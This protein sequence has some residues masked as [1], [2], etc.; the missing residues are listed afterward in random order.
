M[1]WTWQLTTLAALK[2]STCSAAPANA[3]PTAVVKNGTYFG[4][5]NDYYNQDYFLGMPFAQPPVGD[6][7]LAPPV[8]LNTSFS[9]VRNATDFSPG[10]IQF[11][12]AGIDRPLSEDCLSIN[13]IRPS[14]FEN[15]KLPVAVWIYGG[16]YAQGLN[17]DPRYNLTFMVD[18]SVKLGKPIIA[19]SINYRL[20]GFGFLDSTALRAAGLTNLGLR[21]QRLALHWV[22]ENIAA[23]GGNA[24]EV[25]IWGQSAGAGSVGAQLVAYGGRDDGLFRAAITESGGP[26]AFA[27]PTL[28]TSDAT[29]ANILN[30]TGCSGAND[31]I[32]CLRNVPGSVLASAVNA[33]HGS[34]FPH[35][36]NDFLQDYSSVQLSQGK[37]VK[38]P[39][40]TGA[41]ADEGTSFASLGYT[42]TST[43]LNQISAS[44]VSTNSTIRAAGVS[45]IAMLYP[46]IPAIGIPH[47][48]H[49]RPNA[50]YGAQYKRA[51]AFAGDLNIH[52]GRRAAAQAWAEQN[53]PAYS[54]YFNTYPIGGLDPIVG[55]THFAE[56]ALVMNDKAGVGYV[57]P[58][59]PRGSPFAINSSALYTQ[60]DL[61][62]KSL[63]PTFPYY[64]RCTTNL[65]LSRDCFIGC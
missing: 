57:A 34:F 39:L 50:T 40:L 64:S 55:T 51:A 44:I 42:N 45:D 26:L 49:G 15:R 29:Y 48:F 43:I 56:V 54:Y 36:D 31:S 8:P 30:A 20:N 37:F 65:L 3:A 17:R 1:R 32:T 4:L 5:H 14:G 27:G 2:I 22:Q 28:N 61:M 47:T 13:V 63:S 59:Y 24:S 33:S 41:N 38:V 18:N 23:F 58:W 7:R 46:D 19:A 25:T 60:S 52:R 53:L 62:S 35:V 10:C 9:G 12:A 11:L 21:D 6:L 16:G